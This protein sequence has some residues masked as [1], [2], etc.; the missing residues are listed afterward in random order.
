MTRSVVILTAMQLEADPFI[1]LL[2]GAEH[3]EAPPEGMR[4]VRGSLEGRDAMVARTGV[5]LVAAATAATWAATAFSPTAII[6][7]GTA[8]GLSRGI[9][10]G[11]VAVSEAATYGTAD[12]TEFGYERGQV[13]GQPVRFDAAQ[14]LLGAAKDAS[15]QH[16]RFGRILSG[17]TFVTAK[18]VA[19][20]REAFPDAVATDMESCAIAQTA[21]AFGIPWLSVRGISDLCGPEAGQDFHMD[22]A[23]AAER[24]RDVVVAI[25]RALP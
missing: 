3:V 1:E 9:D 11:D 24:S 16:W 23:E 10:V 12:A 18:N 14:E 5:G 20:T 2:E 22:A 4:V 17:D 13:P 19:D 8:G 6:S 15:E 21:S 7:A 25:L